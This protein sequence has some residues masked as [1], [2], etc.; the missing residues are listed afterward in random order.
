VITAKLPSGTKVAIRDNPK[1]PAMSMAD[2]P[3]ALFDD[4]A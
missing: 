3:A 4:D 1:K 2:I